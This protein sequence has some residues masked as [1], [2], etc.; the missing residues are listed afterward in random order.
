MR[1][2]PLNH[3]AIKSLN[4]EIK[5]FHLS[6]RISNIKRATNGPNGNIWLAVKRAKNL[7]HEDIPSSMTLGGNVVARGDLANSFAGYFFNKVKQL[8]NTTKVDSNL[9]NGKNKLIVTNRHFMKKSDV[10]ECIDSLPNKKCEGFDRIPVCILKDC[11]TILLEPLSDLFDKIYKTGLIPDQWKISKIVPIFKKVNKNEIE[12][13]RPIANL[14]SASKIFEKLILK[15]IHY[16]ES[17]NKLDLTGK[18]QHGFKKNKSTAT[19]GAL[20]QSIISRAA[21]E[22]CYVVMASLDLSMAFDL[23]NV[24]LLIIMH[25]TKLGPI[26]VGD[27]QPL[28]IRA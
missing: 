18:Q 4:K 6:N 7:V 11:K 2:I 10:K 13:Y 14:C 26:I 22:N 16:L 20:L 15:Q 24:D 19:A 23:V 1:N 28:T 12:N 5:A 21:D 8:V 3:E 27:K 9:Y 17:T 25:K